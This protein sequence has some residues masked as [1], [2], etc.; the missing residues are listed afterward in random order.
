MVS[1]HKTDQVR[2][3]LE[4]IA[5]AVEA[6]G[7]YAAGFM[8]YEAAPAFD[9]AFKVLPAGPVPLL[10]FGLYDQ[11]E[12]LPAIENGN[13]EA[14][15]LA[16]WKPS[17]SLEEYDRAFSR[18]KAH[19][20][21]G[22]TYQVN[23]TFRLRSRFAGSSWA[24]FRRLAQAQKAAYAAYVDCGRFVLCSASPELF[25]RLEGSQLTCLPMKGTAPRG[26]TLA[27]DRDQSQW[28]LHSEKNRAENL[29]IVDMIR[30]DF[31]RI[32]RFGS[33]E[34]PRLFQIERYPT[35]LQ[36]TSTVTAHTDASLP[37]T[38]AALFPC[39]SI[40]GAPKVS[41][42]QIIASLESAPR[43]VYTGC[44]G[45]M[46]PGRKAQ[47]NVAIRTVTIDRERDQAEYGVG[48]GIVWDSD[49]EEEYRECG[50]KSRVLSAA[51]PS[52]ELLES[53]LWE[54]GSGYFL[55]RQHL[56]RLAD[57]AE[58]FDFPLA[59]N[60]AQ[61]ALDS[62][63]GGLGTSPHKV[64]LLVD[65]AGRVEV[66]AEPLAEPG[67]APA[68]VGLSP[69]PIDSGSP[70]L[71]HKTTHRSVY[72]E[73]LASRPD[74]DDVLLWNER[75][76]LTEAANANIVLQLGGDF[77]TPTLESGLLAGTFRQHL[78]D[79]GTLRAADLPTRLL[80]QAEGLFLINSVRRWRPAV[81]VD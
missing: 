27:E 43:G 16:S 21:L 45:L 22:Q 77:L 56:Q 3:L 60:E 53:L 67:D 34:V 61:E 15:E 35:I 26:R 72:Q 5:A 41:T 31:G 66:Q 46:A 8:A 69:S 74:C 7:L 36:M 48:G 38:L 25:F 49:C 13:P 19:I 29:M 44:I 50:I 37:A 65:R 51:F 24:Y 73:A 6:E 80:A 17:V 62:C 58:Y 10:W 1:T 30:N 54:P 23:Y 39:A 4:K 28:L 18:I 42:M 81:L 76:H 20:E 63:A 75:G 11:F 52:F 47:F 68:R 32:A 55:L 79:Q 78:L 59:L 33:V 2:P 70:F 40:T 12:P 71:Y 14:Y 57:S 64:R 9:P